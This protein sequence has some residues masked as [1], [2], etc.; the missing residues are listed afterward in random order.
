[1]KANLL[2]RTL[3]NTALYPTLATGIAFI[4][5]CL[6]GLAILLKPNTISLP[7]PKQTPNNPET[8]TSKQEEVLALDQYHLFGQAQTP[9]STETEASLTE[10]QQALHLKG[11]FFIAN[12]SA[13]AIIELPDGKQKIFKVNDRLPGGALIE[14][15]ERDSVILSVDN[16]QEILGL[17][18]EASSSSP[19]DELVTNPSLEETQY[20][21][22][23]D[24]QPVIQPPESL[25][26]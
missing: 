18:K 4:Y 1:M 6:V 3:G 19:A 5:L 2:F 12:H 14:R 15:I 20:P 7:L 21:P 25:A 11:L 9:L 26:N 16:Q 24:D 8:L 22:E 13:R 17:H 10:T 23:Y